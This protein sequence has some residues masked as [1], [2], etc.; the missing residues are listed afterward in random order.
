MRTSDGVTETGFL[1]E[2]SLGSNVIPEVGFQPRG[3][4]LSLPLLISRWPRAGPFL[5]G[6]V[7]PFL[8]FAPVCTGLAAGDAQ[9]WVVKG[10]TR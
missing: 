10:K 3:V 4:E 2:T 1:T 6:P 8:A 7:G 9:D 5:P